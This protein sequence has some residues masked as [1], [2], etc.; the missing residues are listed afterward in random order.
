MQIMMISI[1]VSS[2]NFN[3]TYHS[4]IPYIRKKIER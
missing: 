1:I 2:D 3:M 4:D